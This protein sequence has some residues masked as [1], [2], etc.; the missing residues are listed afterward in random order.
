VREV[1]PCGAS[2]CV[3]RVGGGI[4]IIVLARVE[5]SSSA[6]FLIPIT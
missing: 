3:R 2:V 1:V 6:A 5:G 4:G